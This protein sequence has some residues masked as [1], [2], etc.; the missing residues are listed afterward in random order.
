ML[1]RTTALTAALLISA[2]PALAQDATT[3]TPAEAPASETTEA[4]AAEAAAP[5]GE[6]Q[7]SDAVPG[8]MASMIAE[9]TGPE[10]ESFGTVTVAPTPS[11]VMLATI[12]LEGVPEGIHGIHFHET[13]TCTTPDFESAGGHIAGDHEHGVMAEGGA[14]PGDMPN[15][16]VPADGALTVEYF[17]HGL[18]ADMLSDD[19]G[20]AVILHAQ[21]DDYSGQPSG[22]AGP[23]LACGTVSATE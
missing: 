21:P 8:E 9:L 22:N 10:G 15:V 6:A 11:G 23:R 12:T 17:V 4:P 19:D 20:A 7:P 13:G 3:E 14:H 2:W 18:T 5:E 16:H 1:T